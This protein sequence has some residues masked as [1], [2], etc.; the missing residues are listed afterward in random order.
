MPTC[1]IYSNAPKLFFLQIKIDKFSQRNNKNGNRRLNENRLKALQMALSI[2]EGFGIIH[3]PPGTGKTTIIAS[4]I[5]AFFEKST[6]NGTK[7]LCGPTHYV[8]DHGLIF[9]K[10]VLAELF[11]YLC[12]GGI[13][14]LIYNYV[15]LV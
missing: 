13:Q 8:E 3:G 12:W 14:L 4:L 15:T 7:I 2:F 5:P 1:F 9:I 11:Y 6:L 10:M